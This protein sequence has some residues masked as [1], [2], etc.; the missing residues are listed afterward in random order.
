MRSPAAAGAVGVGQGS[1]VHPSLSGPQVQGRTQ[2]QVPRPAFDSHVR[3]D[4]Q[5]PSVRP[6]GLG[7]PRTPP[8]F[9]IHFNV[10]RDIIF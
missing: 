5:I 2:Q 1:S 3:A 6:T 7:D 9:H 4:W 8:V 10:A